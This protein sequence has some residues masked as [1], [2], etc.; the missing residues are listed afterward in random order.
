MS[1]RKFSRVPFKI[2]AEVQS[3]KGIFYGDIRNLSLNGAFI[4]IPESLPVG[5][6]VD[7]KVF[8]SQDKPVIAIDLEGYVVR[9]DPEGIAVKF[10]KVDLDS[11][12]HLRNVIALNSGNGDQV[13]T[14][15]LHYIEERIQE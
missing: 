8:L 13:M 1:D 5:E 7:L 12:T 15:L 6:Y 9:T 10:S 11:F 14:E 3:D 4:A 2:E